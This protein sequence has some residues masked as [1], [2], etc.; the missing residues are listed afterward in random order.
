MSNKNLLLKLLFI[1]CFILFFVAS[2]SEI[3]NTNNYTNSF[4]Y[5]G[6][7]LIFVD[8]GINDRFSNK[9]LT[10]ASLL[11]STQVSFN[12]AEYAGYFI[13]KIGLLITFLSIAYKVFITN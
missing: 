3:S 2:I 1:T 5:F 7:S 12:V 13:G 4:L 11:Q 6:V 8:M 9:R 10:L